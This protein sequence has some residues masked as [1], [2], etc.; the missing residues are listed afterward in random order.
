[1]DPKTN[2]A[3]TPHKDG[4]SLTRHRIERNESAISQKDG[5]VIFDPSVSS[6]SLADGF[7]VFTNPEHRTTAP[8][9]RL[10]HPRR[11]L[12][13][14]NESLTL[15]TDGSCSHNGKLNSI[16]GSGVWVGENHPDNIAAHIGGAAQ[17]NQTGELAAIIIALEHFEHFRPIKFITDSEYVKKG[18]TERLLSWE[19]DGWIGIE[20]SDMFK[21][22]AYLLRNRSAPTTFQW[23][24]G[25]NGTEG[26]DGADELAD[27]GARHTVPYPLNLEVPPKWR[28]SGAKLATLSQSTAYH[29]IRQSAP[30]DTRSGPTEQIAL[31]RDALENFT[32][33]QETDASLWKGITN[34]DIRKPIQTF[35]YRAMQRSY[36]LGDF[37]AKLNDEDK[38][39]CEACG[40]PIESLEHILLQCDTTPRQIIWKLATDLWPHGYDS[41]PE[42]SLGIVLAAGSLEV[43][44]DPQGD[45][46]HNDDERKRNPGATRLLRILISESA[47]LIWKIR[48]E[49]QIGGRTHTKQAIIS[50]WTRA[51]NDRLRSDV[52]AARNIIRTEKAFDLVHLTWK[53]TLEEELHLPFEW[54]KAREVLVGI[55]TPR[56]PT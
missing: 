49:R 36:K 33:K 42:L 22:A 38:A 4:L 39:R 34:K 3:L 45:D 29:G 7:R 24:K 31:A 40:D 37:W 43:T 41:W 15:Y 25:H 8:A 30:R 17:T 20:N 5:E 47:H 26:N 28:L 52:L 50:R 27:Q 53:G 19:D 16:C 35:L 48:C 1:M 9:H 6:K 56:F 44:T 18:L 14:E 21:K 10:L 23:T 32:G 2:P 55:K 51:I 11:G 13:L 46:Q 12:N 54:A